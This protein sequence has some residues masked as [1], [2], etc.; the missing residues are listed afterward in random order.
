[1]PADN[2]RHLCSL[3]FTARN[4]GAIGVDVHL[5]DRTMGTYIVQDGYTVA[6]R[7]GGTAPARFCEVGWHDDAK[8]VVFTIF[9][10]PA[11]RPA[12]EEAIG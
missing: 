2:D 3:A 11:N 12:D 1:M 6:V 4:D 8:V 9:D 7:Q 5:A 10:D